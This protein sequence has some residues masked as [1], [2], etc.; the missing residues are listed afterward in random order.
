MFTSGWALGHLI[1]LWLEA[2]RV[3]YIHHPDSSKIKWDLLYLALYKVGF[4]LY[5]NTCFNGSK[6][7]VEVYFTNQTMFLKSIETS[8]NLSCSWMYFWHFFKVQFLA[9][10]KFIDFHQ[11]ASDIPRAFSLLQNAGTDTILHHRGFI[12]TLQTTKWTVNF[13]A[14][15]FCLSIAIQGMIKQGLNNHNIHITPWTKNI[16][17][18][19]YIPVGE[20]STI[21]WTFRVCHNSSKRPSK[22]R[23]PA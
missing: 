9:L 12:S 11:F 2:L 23:G 17:T 7:L 19:N 14:L 3:G 15:P 4:Y 20:Q 18:S 6:H 5:N 22:S 16:L 10:Q 21:T 8:K 13:N 1:L